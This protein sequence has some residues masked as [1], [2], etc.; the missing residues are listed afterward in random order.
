VFDGKIP[1]LCMRTR[2]PKEMQTFIAACLAQRGEL[3]TGVGQRCLFIRDLETWT[4]LCRS[5][6]GSILIAQP[7]LDYEGARNELLQL[8]RQG[9]HSVIFA[10]T[11]PRA[12]ITEIVDLFEPNRHDVLDVLKKH[13]YS[14]VDA[15]NFA[16]R[17]NGN[18]YILSQLLTGTTERRVWATG[19]EG[20]EFRF[21]ALVGGW[22]DDSEFDQL[23]LSELLNQSYDDWVRRLYPH[24]RE[25]EPP[26][27]LEGK[28]FRPISRY[29]TWQQLGHYLTDADLDRFGSV[30][31]KTLSVTEAVL[32]LP[33]K[34]RATAIFKEKSESYSVAL[35]K[36]IAETLAL[37]G[38]QGKT[39]NCTPTVPAYTADHVVRSL[40]NGASWQVWASLS[41]VMQ[42]LAEASPRAFLEALEVALKDPASG[43]LKEVFVENNDHLFRKS[44]H[45]GLL[46]ALEV[47]AWNPEYLNRVCVCLTRLAS[48]TLSSNMGNNP[49]DTLRSIFLPWLPQ[50][51]A[52][53]DERRIA[54]E[55]IVE[56]DIEI[57]WN[58]LLAILPESHQVGSYHPIP[59]CV[60]GLEVTGKKG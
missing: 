25:A 55:K 38:G 37:L 6:T 30:A 4:K 14:S 50:T 35:R 51:L 42:L 8:A 59:V 19:A 27:L 20:C 44:Y 18:I 13:K 46:W 2:Y 16:R 24:T 5:S 3:E 7:E 31:I 12:D 53:I 39:L 10:L 48:Y 36:G 40:L 22:N 43:P 47:L 49:A 52:T 58:L 17:S 1:E 32:E 29:E 34:E 15:E 54:V 28:S 26:I 21:L 33:Q 45:C 60:T 57:G 56:E 9:Q 11:N 41:D 23:A